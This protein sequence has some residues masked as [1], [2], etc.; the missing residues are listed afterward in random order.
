MFVFSSLRNYPSF[1]HDIY[2]HI[3]H[4]CESLHKI[5]SFLKEYRS[6]KAFNY[7]LID[8]KELASCLEVDVTSMISFNP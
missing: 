3:S 5:I 8:A 7:I 2:C 1:L 6:N 4:A